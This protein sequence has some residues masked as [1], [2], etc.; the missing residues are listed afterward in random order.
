M[1]GL[2]HGPTGLPRGRGTRQP[3]SRAAR[4]P[5]LI[6][7][8]VGGFLGRA[9][10][11]SPDPAVGSN[12]HL[13]SELSDLRYPRVFPT[14]IPWKTKSNSGSLGDSGSPPMGTS[15]SAIGVTIVPQYKVTLQWW[16]SGL[17]A[18]GPPPGKGKKKS[19]RAKT[20]GWPSPRSCVPAST[21]RRTSTRA[22]TR[23]AMVE[24]W[25]EAIAAPG[26]SIF[27]RLET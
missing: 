23:P 4:K 24:G 19:H 1:G 27:S 6:Y 26:E 9:A 8:A 10:T 11:L 14:E 18:D 3:T 17:T 13:R 5:R 21:R 2:I 25:H 16:T 22:C 15:V 20:R 7:W 12:P